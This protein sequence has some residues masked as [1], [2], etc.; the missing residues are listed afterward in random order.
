MDGRETPELENLTA[1]IAPPQIEKAG[2]LPSP[3]EQRE[4]EKNPERAAMAEKTP[5]PSK[6]KAA[7]AKIPFLGR[8]PT[9]RPQ[10]DATTLKIEKILEEG[11]QEPYEKLSPVARQ[12]FKLKGEETATKIRE[13]LNAARVKAKKIVRLIIE[14]LALLPGVNRFFLEQEAK[15]KT[16]HILALKKTNQ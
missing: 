11:L 1:E 13:L 5:Q 9:V 15:I 4:G 14:W 16:D 2:V 7:L 6:S 3:S 10:R 8:R 12:E